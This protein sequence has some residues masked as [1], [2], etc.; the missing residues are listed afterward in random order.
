MRADG[1]SGH[2]VT[3]P[4]GPAFF[5]RV[6]PDGSKLLYATALPL[7]A[8]VDGGVDSALYMYDFATGDATLVTTTEGL[9][10][11]ALSPDGKTVAYVSSYSLLDI[12]VGGTQGR[13]LL[14]GPNDDGTGYGHPT[15]AADPSTIVYATGGVVGAIGIDGTNNET[16]LDAIP[17]SFQYPNPAFSPDYSQ[18]AV[19]AI[20]DMTAPD[21]L[22]LFTYASLPGAPCESGTVLT[23]VT[24]GAS[25]NGAND[26]SWGVNGLIAY[27]SGQDVYVIS[28]SGGQPLNMTAVLTGDGGTVA[29]SDPVWAPACASVP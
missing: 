4:H 28:P 16:L 12:P 27:A 7:D 23:D 15:F 3:L 17:G 14:A 24:E 2:M 9:T 11:S 25:P 13:V 21:A 29:A 19:G 10:Y 26:P 18:I 8:Q 5:P 6:S 20:C 1:S 22:L